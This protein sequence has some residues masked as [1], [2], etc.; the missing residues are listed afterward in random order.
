MVFPFVIDSG[1]CAPCRHLFI[2]SAGLSWMEVNFS[3]QKPCIPSWPGVYQFDIC[4]VLIW[5]N[6]CVFMLSGLLR[7]LLIHL[8]YCLS[9]WPFRCAFLV[10]IFQSKIVRFHLHPVVCVFSC[11]LLPV[12]DRIFF[13]CFGISCFVCNVL[14]FVDIS[15]IFLLS[16]VLSGLFPEVVLLFFLLLSFPFYSYILQRLSFALSFWPV[17]VDFFYLRF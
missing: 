9:I 4:L 12:V 6:R 11:H 7:A 13:R 2:S 1:T 5:V 3:N 10:A 17:F 16:P 14:P 15:F 8:S